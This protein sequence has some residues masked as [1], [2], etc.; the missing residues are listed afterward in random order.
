VLP[1]GGGAVGT[2]V[3]FK[4]RVARIAGCGRLIVADTAAG[5]ANRR[6]RSAHGALTY[7]EE[8]MRASCGGDDSYQQPKNGAETKAS[9]VKSHVGGVIGMWQNN[10][11]LA[12]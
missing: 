5:M 8:H 9:Y 4:R 2:S 11:T 6:Q 3:A 7:H 10:E 1:G 12:A